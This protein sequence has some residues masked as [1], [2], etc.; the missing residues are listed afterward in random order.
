MPS[1]L[2]VAIAL[3]IFI[4][5]TSSAHAGV[6]P[7][8]ACKQKKANATGKKAADLLKAFGRNEKKPN[9]AKLSA[10]VSKAQ[11]KFTKG[12]TKAEAKGGCRTSGDADAIEGK[13]DAF[14]TDV[15][16]NAGPLDVG[17][18]DPDDY[19]CFYVY[20]TVDLF[21]PVGNHTDFS[22]ISLELDP[23]L[24][25]AARLNKSCRI[26]APLYR[27]ITLGTFGTPEAV[28]AL[29]IAYGDVQAA[30]DH[31]MEN[32]NEGRNFVI[33]GHSQGTFMTTTLIQNN[34]DDDPVL[35]ARLIVALL[36]G[37]SVEVP[38]GGVVGETFQNIPLCETN[39]QTGCVIA[40]RTYADGFPPT[41]D[42]NGEPS[43]GIDAACTN[44][45]ALGGG[46]TFL[47]GAYLPLSVNQFLFA[48][49]TFPGGITTPWAAYP[50][51]FEG[52]C[53]KD[54][55][56]RSYLKIYF[57]GQPVDAR[58]NPVL[59]NHLSLDPAFLGAHILDFHF[60]MGDL[61]DLVEQ[62]AA[63]LP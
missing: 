8:A 56:D 47:R 40:Y 59:W 42:S 34:V 9:A 51:F 31:Y 25:Q 38:D 23:L 48:V 58:V 2:S 5:V 28:E 41:N 17:T 63:A 54:S 16:L 12:F 61:I 36:I 57:D 13:V 30:W 26:F 19:D 24:S 21:G 29:A 49:A 39:A 44:P 53:V 7:A 18:E 20:P 1:K 62:K 11:S 22:D 3:G 35:R 15:V 37:G 14:V 60:A 6:D 50:D 46:R 27:Q 52:E 10:D 32:F 4:V 33:M 55:N 45:A 43:P